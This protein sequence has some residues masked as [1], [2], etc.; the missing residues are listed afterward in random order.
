MSVQSDCLMDDN[1]AGSEKK[2]EFKSLA[3]SHLA[4]LPKYI[5]V[6]LH[7]IATFF[8]SP[9]T[10]TVYLLFKRS[11]DFEISARTLSLGTR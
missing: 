8:A 10:K 6:K 5:A 2:S 1:M 3:A 7:W 11:E 9:S 4:N